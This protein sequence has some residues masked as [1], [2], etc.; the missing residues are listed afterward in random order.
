MSIP[1]Y[2][3]ETW[4]MKTSSPPPPPPPPSKKKRNSILPQQNFRA[5]AGKT[6]SQTTKSEN[7]NNK[8]GGSNHVRASCEL[9]G[10]CSTWQIC[11][12]FTIWSPQRIRQ[13]RRPKMSSLPPGDRQE[14]YGWHA[15]ER[16]IKGSCRP[17]THGALRLP[18]VSQTLAV[19]WGP[20]H[21]VCLKRLLNRHNMVQILIQTLLSFTV[22]SLNNSTVIFF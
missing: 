9:V 22:S 5:S 1:M 11:Q 21:S 14:H 12:F 7:S 10:T 6:S 17:K 4:Q 16:C 20:R 8:A 15:M 2:G 13:R 18:N 19:W 3:S